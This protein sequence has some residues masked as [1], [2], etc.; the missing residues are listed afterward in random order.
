MKVVFRNQ[1]GKYFCGWD[2]DNEKGFG[3]NKSI[4]GNF[5][6]AQVFNL[7]REED[8]YSRDCYE[9]INAQQLPMRI[10]KINNRVETERGIEIKTEEI[11]WEMVQLVTAY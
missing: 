6:E 2:W 7:Y 8:I 3:D 10:E 11:H 5:E 4:Q 9:R 1:H